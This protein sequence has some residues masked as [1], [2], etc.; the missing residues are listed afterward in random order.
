MIDRFAK[1]IHDVEGTG[2]GGEWGDIA[3]CLWCGQTEDDGHNEDCVVLAAKVHLARGTPKCCESSH[4]PP[5]TACRGYLESSNGRCVY[6]DHEK[7]CHPGP[8]AT[9]WIGSGE[10]G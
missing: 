1:A 3:V 4:D 8:G 7:K 10:N 6:C 9:C 2:S 5:D